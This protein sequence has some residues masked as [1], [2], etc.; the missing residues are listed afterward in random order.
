MVMQVQYDD[1]VNAGNTKEAKEL[2]KIINGMQHT[3]TKGKY[4]YN[5]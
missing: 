5:D 4:K 1:A 3:H 2:L